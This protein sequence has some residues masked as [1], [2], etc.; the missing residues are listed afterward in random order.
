MDVDEARHRLGVVGCR[1]ITS[2]VGIQEARPPHGLPT[3]EWFLL[4]DGTCLRIIGAATD[5]EPLCFKVSKLE[6]GEKALGYGGKLKWFSQ[7]REFVERVDLKNYL[8]P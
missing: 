8:R 1:E 2:S 6:I 3:A 7:Q 4:P 5:A